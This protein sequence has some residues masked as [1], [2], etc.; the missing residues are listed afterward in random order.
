M[1]NK[2]KF[3][4]KYIKSEEKTK[5]KMEIKRSRTK[6]LTEKELM[7]DLS[8]LNEKQEKMF[9]R[10]LSAE[11]FEFISPE[12][13]KSYRERIL[14]I[15]DAIQL[16]KVPDRVPVVLSIGFF[17]AYYSG[18]T[19]RDVMYDYDKLYSAWKRYVLDFQPDAHIGCF[20]PG[21]GR[22]FDLLD[23]KLYAWPGHGTSPEHSYQCLEK[24]YMK[25]DEY[26]ALIEDPSGFF[27]SVYLPRIFGALEPLK[28]LSPLT[29][30]LEIVFVGGGI[31]PYGLPEVQEAYK[32]LLE[33]GSEALKWGGILGA[34]DKEMAE[35]GYPNFFGGA[36]KAPF[37][38]LG[39]TLRG[40]RGI[41]MDIHRQPKKLL[42]A[43]ERLVP[44]MIKFGVAGVQMSGNPIVFIPLHK[45]ADS[46]LSNEQYKEFYWP[47]FRK[48]LMGLI[49]EGCIP[50]PYAEG[51]YNTR[52]EIIKD[53]PKGKVIW[54]LDLTDMT[55]AKTILGSS[56]CIAGN[57]PITLLNVGAPEQVKYY[58]EALIDSA[59]ENGGFIMMNGTVIEEAKPENVKMM[60]N[61]TKEYGIYKQN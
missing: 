11:N 56:A 21:P 58:T 61:T 44:L 13:E 30:I 6:E 16:K 43:C 24:E 41:M 25:R 2:I 52:L 37:D 22:I 14:R 47:S 23:Y 19:P 32:K 4:K 49:E 12:A 50:F 36:T 17:P 55:A 46:F 45:G 59:S 7:I 48:L 1:L 28:N 33:A 57:V 53:L 8:E 51:S 20:V 54:G 31:L 9:E 5:P 38:T 26:D 60:I 34:F 35:L 3:W 42:E 29:N 40:T 10:W 18:L 15:K 39:D 27:R